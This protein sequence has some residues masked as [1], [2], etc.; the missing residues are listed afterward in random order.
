MKAPLLDTHTWVWWVLDGP[1]LKA[2]EKRD[3]KNLKGD[4]RPFIASISLWEVALLVD[5]GRLT[6][7]IPL[8]R[9]LELAAHPDSV[10]IVSITPAIAAGVAML[11]ESMHRDP[12]DRLIVATCIELGLPIF[13]R[14]RKILSSKLVTA[15][16]P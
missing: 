14:D 4:N 7:N 3:L 12:A 2:K 10:N 15:W 16:K 9:W 11:P 5:C 8:R 1:E 13:T 6:L